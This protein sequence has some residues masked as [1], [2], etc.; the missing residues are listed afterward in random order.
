MSRYQREVKVHL[1]EKILERGEGDYQKNWVGVCGPLHK[2]LTLFM[3]KICDFLFRIYDLTK[4]LITYLWPDPHVHCC[5]K[6]N[7]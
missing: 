3:T 2:T 4:I 6:H 1:P 5:R 7:F